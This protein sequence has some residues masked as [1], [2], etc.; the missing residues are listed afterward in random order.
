M[1]V[2]ADVLITDRNQAGQHRLGIQFQVEPRTIFEVDLAR[3]F[4][5]EVMRQV[6]ADADVCGHQRRQVSGLLHLLQFQ[7]AG[8][9]FLCGAGR[10][11]E[12]GQDVAQH[13]WGDFLRAAVGVDPVDCQASSAGQYFQL[14]ITH[15]RSPSGGSKGAAAVRLTSAQ[16]G[17]RVP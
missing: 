7:Q 9:D 16:Y 5:L 10:V 14:R 15:W 4:R 6:E 11:A 13:R 8:V 2:D 12:S 17:A 3:G 1:S